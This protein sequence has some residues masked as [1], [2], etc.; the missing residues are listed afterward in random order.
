MSE[1]E[2]GGGAFLFNLPGPVLGAAVDVGAIIQ[3]MLNDAEPAPGARLMECAVARVVSVVDLADSV[4]Q[5]VQHH[6]LR[7]T[8]KQNGEPLFSARGCFSTR[9]DNEYARAVA[10]FPL[11]GSCGRGMTGEE[12][13]SVLLCRTN[14]RRGAQTLHNTGAGAKRIEE[15]ESDST[16]LC[17]PDSAR[18]RTSE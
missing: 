12:E 7:E 15:P 18:A 1:R 8:A 2:G 16:A 5:A 10:A 17:L 13:L 4:L 6:L 14:I 9:D 11:Y 3:Q